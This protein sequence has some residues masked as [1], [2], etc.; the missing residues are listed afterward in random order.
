M[1]QDRFRRAATTLLGGG[2]INRQTNEELFD[3]LE[4]PGNIEQLTEYLGRVGLTPTRTSNE[5]TW[6]A[7][8]MELNEENR[9]AARETA[10]QAKRELRYWVGFLKLVMD[11]LDEPA[12]VAGAIFYSHRLLTA[13]Q[14]K[15]NLQETLRTLA[16]RLRSTSDSSIRAS[17]DSVLRWA[18]R[19]DQNLLELLDE[20]KELYRLTG[21]VDWVIDMIRAFDESIERPVSVSKKPA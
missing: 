5:Q 11:A 13:V 15:L 9:A 20:Q 21:K 16:Q 7:A 10:A 4:S 12:P 2:F 17:L 3:F 19:P 8:L 1:S 6:Y 18:M 14:E